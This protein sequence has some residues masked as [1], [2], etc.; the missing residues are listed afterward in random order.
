MTT[1]RTP[2]ML[3]QRAGDRTDNAQES[4]TQLTAFNKAGRSIL[5]IFAFVSAAAPSTA[6]MHA[7]QVIQ[8]QPD[9]H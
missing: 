5:A 7:Q 1:V 8:F 6:T 4:H 9:Q 3:L 2:P